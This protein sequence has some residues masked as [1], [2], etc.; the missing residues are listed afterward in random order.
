MTSNLHDWINPRH[1]DHAAMAAAATHFAEDPCSTV[2]FD[3]FLTPNRLEALRMIYESDGDFHPWYG[4]FGGISHSDTGWELVLKSPK[5]GRHAG[6][7]YLTYL[8]LCNVINSPAFAGYLARITGIR[9]DAIQGLQV[10][11]TPPGHRVKPHTDNI[12]NRRLCL[13]LYPGRHWQPGYGS[14]FLQM[15]E[16]RVVREL[17]PLPNR[18][19]IFKVSDQSLHAVE[20]LAET[21][22]PRWGLTIW[23]SAP[24]PA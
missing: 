14:R 7:G 8:L 24:A 1:L 10:R 9:P 23:M 16:G 5:P 11:I 3:D 17:E 13:V 15:R 6:T 4:D 20:P 12:K 19:V 21:A 18:L 2:W 22:P